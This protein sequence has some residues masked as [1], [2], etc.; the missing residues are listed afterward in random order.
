MNGEDLNTK[1][2]AV[3]AE[4]KDLGG[5]LAQVETEIAQAT[6]DS[7]LGRLQSKELELIKY[8]NLLLED[9]KQLECDAKE[10][11]L[12]TKTARSLHATTTSA[13]ISLKLIEVP[14]ASIQ[15]KS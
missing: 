4:L 6:D 10:L 14:A 2:R 7:K 1:L 3:E 9:K 12:Q 8:R 5:K 15:D 11:K 13:G